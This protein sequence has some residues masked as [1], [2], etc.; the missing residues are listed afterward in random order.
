M[1]PASFGKQLIYGAFVYVFM[2]V[3]SLFHYFLVTYD[4]HYSIGI[5]KLFATSYANV[6][7]ERIR[8]IT[9][10]RGQN[11][12]NVL[13]KY[14][15]ML[16]K[17]EKEQLSNK[18]KYSVFTYWHLVHI[19]HYI[20]LGIFAPRL[21]PF[22][23]VFGILFELFELKTCNCHDPLDILYNSLGFGIGVLLNFI[24]FRSGTYAF[25]GLSPFVV[26][27]CVFIGIFILFYSHM[28]WNVKR[29]TE[30]TEKSMNNANTN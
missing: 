4:G 7:D 26:A 5:R 9:Q 12:F 25:T 21:L 10:Y 29:L 17:E 18:H 14:L 19:W 2:I 24:I 22:V 27:F 15:H 8:F 23:I 11:S 28:S 1:Y 20:G 13:D 30:E 6:A 3:N 16:T